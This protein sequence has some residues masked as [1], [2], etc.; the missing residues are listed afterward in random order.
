[1]NIQFK[2]AH[3]GNYS[4]GRAYPVEYIVVHYTANSGDTAK[5]NAD[6]FAREKTGTSAHYFVDQSEVWQ[7]VKDSDTAYHCGSKNPVHPYCRNSNSI[8]VEMCDSL[9]S[10]PEATM[11]RTAEL[12]RELMG[13]YEVPVDRVLRHYDVTGKNCPAPWVRAPGEWDRFKEMLEGDDMTEDQVRAIVRDEYKKMEEQRAAEPA[14]SWAEPYIRKAIEIGAMTNVGT[15]SEPKI[16]RPQ[17]E[18][19]R[20]EVAVVAAALSVGVK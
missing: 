7:V 10:V 8:G 16:D 4:S 14:D 11:E 12:V 3:Q 15:G 19:T 18:I 6:Y 2:Q 17:A 20:Q 5:N 9:T 1:M 13:R